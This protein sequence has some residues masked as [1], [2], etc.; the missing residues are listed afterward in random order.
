MASCWHLLLYIRPNKSW[1]TLLVIAFIT[2]TALAAANVEDETY[3]VNLILRD[4]DNSSGQ[5]QQQ[6]DKI[7]SKDAIKR[8]WGI[9]DAAAVA[10]KVF[11]YPIPDDAFTG[12]VLKYEAGTDFF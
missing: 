12:K 11:I 1:K 6:T 3:Y 9:S 4:L 8:H 2:T 7:N 5:E 10:G